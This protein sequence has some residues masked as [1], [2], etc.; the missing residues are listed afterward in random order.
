MGSS[1]VTLLILRQRIRADQVAASLLV[2]VLI[3]NMNP[4]DLWSPYYRITSA[5]PSQATSIIVNGIPHSRY[6]R[7]RRQISTSP[8]ARRSR[9]LATSDNRRWHGNDVLSALHGR[10]TSTVIGR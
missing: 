9:A 4:H 6:R 7:R 2:E 3:S 8:I 1:A 10:G 5:Q